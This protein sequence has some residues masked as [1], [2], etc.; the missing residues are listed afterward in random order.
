MLEQAKEP[1]EFNETHA[2]ECGL[3]GRILYQRLQLYGGKVSVGTAILACVL[4]NGSPGNIVM[5]AFTLARM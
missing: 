2:A 5:Y 1:E 4:S 3:V